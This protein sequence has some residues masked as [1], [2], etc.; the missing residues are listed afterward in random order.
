MTIQTL[1]D[2]I[3]QPEVGPTRGKP[4]KVKSASGGYAYVFPDN[5]E[6]WLMFMD[7]RMRGKLR[8]PNMSWKSGDKCFC[9][10]EYGIVET[11]KSDGTI[12]SVR[13]NDGSVTAGCVPKIFPRTERIENISNIC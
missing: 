3:V 7:L 8:R 6:K 5:F 10:F 4:K 13:L 9:E 2:G 11:V 1:F 12:L